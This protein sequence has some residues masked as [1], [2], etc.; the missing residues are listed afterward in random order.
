MSRWVLLL[1]LPGIPATAG[2]EVWL[3]LYAMPVRSRK[4]REESEEKM[5]KQC[6]CREINMHLVLR[7]KQLLITCATKEKIRKSGAKILI[8]LS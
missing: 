2:S 6:I 1:Y 7:D 3:P 5:P 8:I 4:Q